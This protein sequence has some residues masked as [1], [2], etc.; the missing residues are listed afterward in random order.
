MK[1][2]EMKYERPDMNAYEKQM[3]ERLDSLEKAKN[4]DEFMPIFKEINRM[5]CHLQTMVQLVQIRHTVNT[6]DPFY[7][8]EHT[9]WDETLPSCQKLENRFVR[10]CIH[11]DFRQDLLKSIPETF[12]Q[13]GECAIRSFDPKI[14]PLMVEENKLCSEYGKLKASAEIPFHGE[15][16]NLSEIAAKTIDKDRSVRKEAMDAKMAFFAEHQ[17]DFDRIYDSLVHVRDRMAKELGYPNYVTLAYYRMNRLDYNADMVAEY[18]RQV[19]KYFTPASSEIYEKQKKRLGYDQLA[20]YDL[21]YEFKDGNATP[22]GNSEQLIQD[23]IRMYHEMSPETGEFIDLM[24]QNELWDLISRPNKEMGGYTTE[25]PDYKCP[26]IFSNFNGTSG[27]VDVLTH[28][29]GHAFQSYMS[30]NI[31]IPDISFP[32][33]ESCEIHS[34]S[35]EFFAYP[36]MNSFFGDEADKYRYSH[37]CGTITFLPY[38]VLVDHFQQS[39]YENPDW[40]PAQRNQEWRRLEKMYQ[41]YKNYDGCEILEEG[42]WW[43]QQNHIFQSPFYYIDYTLAQVC[44]QQ[45]LIRMKKKDPDTWKDYLHLCTLGGTESFTSLVKEAG[46][47][48]PFDPECIPEVSRQLKEY[49]DETDDTKL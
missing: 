38:G 33:M 30:R 3:T 1:F 37:L 11:A 8:T 41:P 27:D 9:Y 48:I 46:L 10:I 47:K 6:A 16:L 42:G 23:A 45:F 21:A 20:Y 40:T 13:L 5:R 2:N 17:N 12:F 18:R 29:A 31:D 25:L 14:V 24:N 34:M 19:L 32:T 35:M 22:K 36:W 7:D 26:F 49:L 28:E 39:V 43:Y 15:T 44:A 4:A